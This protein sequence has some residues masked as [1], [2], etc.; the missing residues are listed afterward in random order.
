MTAR[1]T[2]FP[3]PAFFCPLIQTMLAKFYQLTPGRRLWLSWPCNEK[4]ERNK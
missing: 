2:R 1:E 3:A 4:P